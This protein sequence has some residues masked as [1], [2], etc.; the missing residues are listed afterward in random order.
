MYKICLIACIVIIC[1]I[2]YFT[3]DNVRE[4]YSENPQKDF[5]DF[6]NE[7]LTSYLNKYLIPSANDYIKNM[8][9]SRDFKHYLLQDLICDIYVYA[10]LH[11]ITT[12]TQLNPISIQYDNR[13]NNVIT[14]KYKIPLK[15]TFRLDTN[16]HVCG[17]NNQSAVFNLDRLLLSGTFQIDCNQNYKV[18]FTID[19]LDGT[20]SIY[21][22]VFDILKSTL[23]KSSFLINPLVLT[24]YEIFVNSPDKAKSMIR[25]G[26]DVNQL[27][28]SSLKS[29]LEP[30]IN[31]LP[32]IKQYISNNKTY[33]DIVT[34]VP[35]EPWDIKDVINQPF[36]YLLISNLDTNMMT[37]LWG[38]SFTKQQ[39]FI[40]N[41]DFSSCYKFEDIIHRIQMYYTQQKMPIPA[42]FFH[43][44]KLLP[45]N[46]NAPVPYKLLTSVE[47]FTDP[48]NMIPTLPILG[49]LND[50]FPIR[51]QFSDIQF[52]LT[53]DQTYKGIKADVYGKNC[54]FPNGTFTVSNVPATIEMTG[55]LSPFFN[56]LPIHPNLEHIIIHNLLI[57]S[58]DISLCKTKDNLVINSLTVSLSDEL[59]TNVQTNDE[60]VDTII[61]YIIKQ[62]YGKTSSLDKYLNDQL[63]VIKNYEIK[64]KNDGI[65]DT[66]RALCN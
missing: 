22:S 32:Q 21:D 37:T 27:I 50:M 55:N 42:G 41:N 31:S 14:L 19:Q 49:I 52:L 36:N 34:N 5:Q 23:S 30:Y 39:M 47:S 64:L 12:Q 48:C 61:N 44:F 46:V 59:K 54:S 56:S 35:E 6:V 38:K 63:N 26:I 4:G 7:T 1:L 20:D 45:I 2:L 8:T 53:I 16:I 15:L 62:N 29:S 13:G 65:I 24:F 28:I 60:Q 57:E 58:M 18:N 43:K 25:D 40:S 11:L 33:I 51:M 66:I 3:S 17:D 9:L 10:N